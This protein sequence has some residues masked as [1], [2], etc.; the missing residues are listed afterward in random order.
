MA[1]VGRKRKPPHLR[2]IEGNRGKRPIKEGVK[3]PALAPS[4]PD[5]KLVFPGTTKG[6][7]EVRDDAHNEWKRVV[8][9]LDSK[10]LLATIDNTLLTDY[11]ICWAR[12]LEAERLVS[13]EGMVLETERGWVKHPAT[14]VAAGCRQQL[15]FYIGELGLS[16]SSRGRIDLPGG[17]DEGDDVLD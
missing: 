13:R 8:P 15:K 12:L 16:P 1:Q 11:C 17:D 9:V 6:I 2:E 5:W 3:L 7:G 14:T 4:E 10:K